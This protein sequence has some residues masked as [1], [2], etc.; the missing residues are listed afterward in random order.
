MDS[1]ENLI[2][3][4]THIWGNEPVS[5]FLAVKIDKDNFKV[6]SVVQWPDKKDA[7][8]D[9]LLSWSAQ[10]LEAYFSPATYKPNSP[11]KEKVNV[12]GS[13][14]LWVDLDGNAG[15]ALD[16]LPMLQGVP[17]PTWRVQTGPNGHEHWYWLLDR[18]I[19][20]ESFEELNQKLAYALNADKGCW[21]AGR[22][23][24]PPFTFNHKEKYRAMEN[25]PLP[26]DFIEVNENAYAIESFDKLQSVNKSSRESLSELGEIPSIQEVLAK[27]KWDDQH[28]DLFF[29]PGELKDKN[30][31]SKRSDSIV[32]L[33]Y[34]GAEVGMTDAAIYAV[35]SDFDNR[36]GKFKDRSDRERRLSEIIIKARSKYPNSLASTTI[37]SDES[38]QTVF[39][40]NELLNAE[41]NLEW[42]I[43]DFL[44]KGTINFIS[45]QSG[46]GKSRLSMQLAFACATGGDFL[47]WKIN[48]PMNVMYLSLEM[49]GPMLKHFAHGLVKDKSYSNDVSERF[50][51]V[52]VGNPIP[53]TTDEGQRY[54]EMLI[55]EHQPQL[56]FIDALG[57]LTFEE[58]KEVQAKMINTKLKG[59][60][61]KFGTTF[62]IVH[63]N[64]KPPQGQARPTL[65]SIYGSQY[66]VT[67]SAVVLTMYNPNE[68]DTE[69]IPVKTRAGVAPDIVTMDGRQGFEFQVKDKVNV[70]KNLFDGFGV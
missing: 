31:M 29:N 58:L 39:S 3:F 12:L 52:P 38:V 56:M 48:Q 47:N 30:G 54:I 55:E 5:V 62:F 19:E 61:N 37:V 34:F 13:R 32:R 49:D 11:N 15:E 24:R 68:E 17:Q 25:Y 45:A 65:N 70:P 63:H 22:V 6:P 27:Y 43:D 18:Q 46:I 26:V 33:A 40:L 7:I 23:M 53:F 64:S 20:R 66:V 14:V 69:L 41:F 57:S 50:K 59:L 35:I 4:L 67:D 42:L 28:A 2:E 21:D 10:K 9:K 8:A 36:V 60:I 1:R 44:P 51:L 16:V